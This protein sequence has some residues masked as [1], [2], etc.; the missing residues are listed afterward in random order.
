MSQNSLSEETPFETSSSEEESDIEM[1]DEISDE[2]ISLAISESYDD[3]LSK[4]E[5]R[6]ALIKQL[7]YYYDIIKMA[8]HAPIWQDF[9][10]NAK[11]FQINNSSYNSRQALEHII[12][13]NKT[14]LMEELKKHKCSSN[15]DSEAE[16]E[17]NNITSNTEN[18]STISNFR[19][20]IKRGIY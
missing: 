18:N 16:S 17:N 1:E 2:L 19:A 11:E 20:T 5:N 13:S 10:S 9:R 3:E 6:K 15:S 14:R 12:S 7:L 8:K 4:K